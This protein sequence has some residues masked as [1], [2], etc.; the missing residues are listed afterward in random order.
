MAARDDWPK[1][2]N[3]MDFDG[4]HLLALAREGKSPFHD[5]WDV[6]LLV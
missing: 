2:P 1:M 5:R 4:R 3:G 6:N